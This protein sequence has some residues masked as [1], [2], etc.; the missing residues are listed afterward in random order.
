MKTKIKEQSSGFLCAFSV[1]LCV[2]LLSCQKEEFDIVNLNNNRIIALGHSGMGI[3]RVYPPDSYES[4]LNC[5][6][7]GADGTEINVQMTKDNVLVAFHD[8]DLKTN[9]NMEGL[10]NSHTWA[11]LENAY[12]DTYPYLQFS[13]LNFDNF[14]SKLSKPEKYFFTFDC[15]LFYSS[16]RQTFLEN[17]STALIALIEKYNLQNRMTIESSDVDFLLLIQQQKPDYKLFF[18]PDFFEEG[19]ETVQQYGFSGITIDWE[20][21]SKEEVA[22]AHSLGIYIATWNTPHQ[23]R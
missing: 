22:L 1:F 3:G 23:A 10:I 20:N 6:A 19:L 4:V 11:E 5:L 18:Y 8:E 7:T 15:K 17:Y 21:I 2:S 16:D 14:F 12:Y 9:T 13:I